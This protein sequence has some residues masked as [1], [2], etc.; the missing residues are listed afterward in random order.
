MAQS[1]IFWTW[2]YRL[3]STFNIINVVF[4]ED[5]WNDIANNNNDSIDMIFNW[6][7]NGIFTAY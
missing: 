6:I 2:L 7:L 1:V 4:C 5:L 3:F